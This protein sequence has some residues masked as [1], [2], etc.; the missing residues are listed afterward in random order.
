MKNTS[1]FYNK[2]PIVIFG[3]IILACLTG[4]SI[5]KE[6]YSGLH[7][8]EVHEEQKIDENHETAVEDSEIEELLRQYEL[9]MIE[10]ENS[11]EEFL[12]LSEEEQFKL[13]APTVSMSFE[14]LIADDGDYEWPVGFPS[15]DT[16]YIKVNLNSHV[17]AVYKKGDSGEYDMPVR[18]MLC[19][20]GA[21]GSATP[22][23]SFAMHDHRV[24]FAIFNNTDVYA[25]YWTQITGRIY[26]HS[27]LYSAKDDSTYTSSWNNLGKS[28]SH[29]CVRLTVPD[30]RWIWYNIAPG[31]KIDITYDKDEEMEEIREKLTVARIPEN[32]V[33]MK[34]YVYESTDVWRKDDVSIDVMST[35]T[36]P[37]YAADALR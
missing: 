28:V 12:E 14:E 2:T 13:L 5:E 34:N 23:G 16:Y 11:R 25:Q 29:G 31:T 18:Y 20:S 27:A 7:A 19:S 21:S 36:G 15:E 37:D 24:R 33:D 22:S 26:F 17:V 4:C 9:E 8:V 10:E 6:D 3:M 1:F 32:G 30:A 35:Q